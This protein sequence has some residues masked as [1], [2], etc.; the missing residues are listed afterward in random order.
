MWPYMIGA[1]VDQRALTNETNRRFWARTGHKPGQRLD[2]K[3]PRDRMM[4]EVWLQIYEEVRA[5]R[6]YAHKLAWRVAG[7]GSSPYVL[8]V[9]T[10][11]GSLRHSEFPQRL[12][13]DVQFTWLM[14][15]PDLF[16]YAAAFDFTTQQA[17][18]HEAFSSRT[19][20]GAGS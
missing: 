12:N 9:E 5:L 13:L 20:T 10:P 18:L 14:D 3:D 6:D 16:R 11:D 19:S 15:Q 7:E 8:I 1:V 17:P 2:M 4:S